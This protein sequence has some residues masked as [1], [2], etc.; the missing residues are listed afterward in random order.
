MKDHKGKIVQIPRPVSAMRI[1][2]PS[3][4]K[5]QDVRARLDGAPDTE[6]ELQELWQ[7]MIATFKRK[8]GKELV[9]SWMNASTPGG[10]DDLDADGDLDPPM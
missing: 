4:N 7:G 3:K 6:E 5:Y 10:P 8:Y 2:D 1:W 9:V